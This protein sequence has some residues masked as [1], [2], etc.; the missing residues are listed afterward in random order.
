MDVSVIIVTYN[1]LKMTKECIDSIVSKTTGV[2][3]EII[4]VD[5]A[6]TDGSKEYF[7][8]DHRVKYIYSTTNLGFGNGNNLGV[9]SATGK[10]IFYLNSDTLLLNNAIKEFFIWMESQPEEIGC[11]GCMLVNRND[12]PVN[13]FQDMQGCRYFLRDVLAW[14]HIKIKPKYSSSVLPTLSYPRKVGFVVGADLFVR[15]SCLDKCGQ[16]D[17]DF[18]M[19]YEETEMQY[20]FHHNGYQS[21]CINTPKIKHLV[22]Q[23][24]TKNKEE[25]LRRFIGQL[26]SRY[27]YIKK[28][29][30][31]LQR[32]VLYSIHLLYLPA[33]IFKKTQPGE[34]KEAAAFILK[35]FFPIK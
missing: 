34:K 2:E 26:N 9:Q 32:Y 4:L 10:Y 35:P 7:E 21:W 30:N 12:K 28:T 3:F 24:I 25:S 22:G 23:S 20:R 19:Y 5:N 14:Y 1:T 27:L 6:S 17:P 16:F 8:N 33:L 31:F 18:F 13:S 15:R 11:C 29:K